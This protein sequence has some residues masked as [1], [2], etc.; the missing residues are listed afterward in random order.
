MW[1]PRLLGGCVEPSRY[2]GSKTHFVVN[3]MNS[4][5]QETIS[6]VLQTDNDACLPTGSDTDTRSS[7][8]STPVDDLERIVQPEVP[9]KAE[10]EQDF[11]DF[12]L[13]RTVKKPSRVVKNARRSKPLK[14]LRA[15]LDKPKLAK[16]CA[17]FLS[18]VPDPLPEF[19][20]SVRSIA[21]DSIVTSNNYQQKLK[22]CP[23]VESTHE[24]VSDINPDL[25][26]PLARYLPYHVSNSEDSYLNLRAFDRNAV[27]TDRKY[28]LRYVKNFSRFR[29][30]DEYYADQIAFHYSKNPHHPEHWHGNHMDFASTVEMMND[31]CASAA[32]LEQ[33]PTSLN[34]VITAVSW[35]FSV[36]DGKTVTNEKFRNMNGLGL[37]AWFAN[38]FRMSVC[39]GAIDRDFKYPTTHRKSI[40]EPFENEMWLLG[41]MAGS[42]ARFLGAVKESKKLKF[43]VRETRYHRWLVDK[44]NAEHRVAGGHDAD[45]ATMVSTLAYA[46][47]WFIKDA[48]LPVH[49]PT[50]DDCDECHTPDPFRH[51][52][53]CSSASRVLN[54]ARNL[55]EG[56]Q[57]SIKN[58]VGD[59]ILS[60]DFA[61][62]TREAIRTIADKLGAASDAFTDVFSQISDMILGLK[63]RILSLM[64]RIPGFSNL[65]DGFS[66][67]N[68][69]KLVICY[70]L[71][72]H[73]DSVVMRGLIAAAA[74]AVLKS[75]V[76][77]PLLRD[78]SLTSL[79]NKISGQSVEEPVIVEPPESDTDEHICT[80]DD[81]IHENLIDRLF[82]YVTDCDVQTGGIVCCFLITLITGR[83]CAT[84][85]RDSI[86]KSFVNTFKNLHFI[87]AGL[88]GM[89]R[90]IRYFSTILKTVINFF[91]LAIGKT[92]A[93]KAEQEKAD[94]L[95]NRAL[96]WVVYVESYR[97]EEGIRL[98]RSSA[99]DHKRAMNLFNES[100]EFVAAAHSGKL[101]RS[102]GIH[103]I[104][105]VSEAQKIF[106]T[107]M[108]MKRHGK[109]R[110]TPFHIQFYGDPGSGKSV[111]LQN[112]IPHLHKHYYPTRPTESLVYNRSTTEHWDGYLGQPI[113]VKDEAYPARIPEKLIEDLAI[114]SC[115]PFLTPQAELHD[116]GAIYLESEFYL[117]S[118]NVPY[119]VC[120]DVYDMRAIHRRRHMLI[121][122]RCD[123]R[124]K[125]PG[126]N[127]F[128]AEL[129]KKHFPGQSSRDFPHLKFDIL[130][131]VTD[132]GQPEVSEECYYGDE[133][134]IPSGLIRPLKDLGYEQLLAL[135]HTRRAA[136]IS[137]EK[138]AFDGGSLQKHLKL[139]HLEIENFKA[140]LL[141]KDPEVEIPKIFDLNSIDEEEIETTE[142]RTSNL[143]E[144]DFRRIYNDFFK[145]K[146]EAVRV[147]DHT[148]TSSD[149]EADLD[150]A[151]ALIKSPDFDLEKLQV[152]YLRVEKVF[153]NS[154]DPTHPS[155]QKRIWLRALTVS[156]LLRQKLDVVENIKT[157]KLFT[158]VPAKIHRLEEVQ[159]T[160]PSC[161]RT[162]PDTKPLSVDEE[163][164]RARNIL[165]NKKRK[166]AENLIETTGPSGKKT[167]RFAPS[168]ETTLDEVEGNRTDRNGVRPCAPYFDM[169]EL[170]QRGHTH[171]HS[172]HRNMSALVLTRLRQNMGHFFP[173]FQFGGNLAP[174]EQCFIEVMPFTVRGG[175]MPLCGRGLV[176][177]T[178]LAG[179]F[180]RI[181]NLYNGRLPLTNYFAALIDK[182]EVDGKTV[183][184]LNTSETRSS[185]NAWL[186][187]VAQ[188]L[189][190]TST[191]D[192]PVPHGF[193]RDKNSVIQCLLLSVP[194][195]FDS[196]NFFMNDITEEERDALY[197]YMRDYTFSMQTIRSF[198]HVVQNT[199]IKKTQSLIDLVGRTCNWVMTSLANWKT[200]LYTLGGA[201]LVISILRGV[202]H[203]IAPHTP[204]S[205]K[206]FRV[207]GRRPVVTRY[208]SGDST[209]LEA[210]SRYKKR[211]IVE[212]RLWNWDSPDVVKMASG[213]R[214]GHYLVTVAHT[215]SAL[216][217]GDDED[218]SHFV[219]EFRPT[220]YSP[221]TWQCTI[222]CGSVYFVP[223]TDIAVTYLRDFAPAPDC[224][225]LFWTEDEA[226]NCDLP[227][228]I[229]LLRLPMGEQLVS[230]YSL[231][232]LAYSHYAFKVSNPCHRFDAPFIKVRWH[233]P[234]G[235][236]GCPAFGHLPGT[237]GRILGLQS[238]TKDGNSY[239]AVLTRE[240]LFDAMS[241]FHPITHEGPI[242]TTYTAIE[243]GG[244]PKSAKYI[245]SHVQL[246]GCVKPEYVLGYT[247]GTALRET[248]L[249]EDFPSV[250]VPALLN[251][252]DPRVPPG[253]H[254]CAHSFNKT[255]RDVMVPLD[256]ELVEMAVDGMS[257]YYIQRL[258]L[259]KLKILDTT[260]TIR[261]YGG[262]EPI[263]TKT[264]PGIPLIWDRKPGFPGKKQF[265]RYTETG[266]I[267]YFSERVK[268]EMEYFESSMEWGVIPEAQMYEFP[269]DELRP[270]LKALGDSTH[271]QKTRTISVFPMVINMLYRKYFL[272]FDAQ[273]HTWADGDFPIS[274][275]MNPEGPAFTNAFYRLR[276]ASPFVMAADISNFDGHW[277]AQLAF[278]YLD[279]IQRC[280]AIA[281]S[282]S[283]GCCKGGLPDC[284]DL[285]WSMRVRQCIFDFNLFGHFQF[286][287]ALCQKQRG[288]SSGFAGTADVNSGSHLL[289]L[290][291][292]YL[293]AMRAY[294]SLC[295]FDEFLAHV[296]SLIY[297]DDIVFS[298]SP[299]VSV[300]FNVNY[301]VNFMTRHGWPITSADKKGKVE[302]ILLDRADFLKRKF[303]LDYHLGVVFAALSLDTISDMLHWI[304][305]SECPRNQLFVNIRL[306]LEY[307]FPH[308]YEVYNEWRD[309]IRE[310]LRN[311]SIRFPLP[312]YMQTRRVMLSRYYGEPQEPPLIGES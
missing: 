80:S 165:R 278:A 191:L 309:R 291:I 73:F 231:P 92:P 41:L 225:R 273:V 184:A 16:T 287:D 265:L 180:S 305:K 190:R 132:T 36:K 268:E 203:F 311:H 107:A 256:P 9:S 50:S 145:D 63:T 144:E 166:L 194:G 254:P 150:Q 205:K 61:D 79:W 75:M 103:V 54:N 146:K 94:D 230:Q 160:E 29:T 142:T 229:D 272:A 284:D 264:S 210:F 62:T 292:C 37:L 245:E 251:P 234:R 31:L 149:D 259:T 242:A 308:G 129:F 280:Y 192:S 138:S 244:F 253:T 275:G 221:E 52:Q 171:C 290:Y 302:P 200:V 238:N 202:A 216:M 258:D 101:P 239:I 48:P 83:F 32:R 266:E 224:H 23:L 270:I 110:A 209:Y 67:L 87:G 279:V 262:T 148:E 97:T 250:S 158:G 297:G 19:L 301:Y 136:M 137:E 106:N 162:V 173:A 186:N 274:V 72:N 227:D 276:H 159:L 219:M 5:N 153:T 89:D 236:S 93:E 170:G 246:V 125:H 51:N 151:E 177:P 117:T 38:V 120:G 220:L 198:Q 100:V 4:Q 185:Y 78:F 282:A 257:D 7:G 147:V 181:L 196:I 174:S 64:E 43:Y 81:E 175:H 164:A 304:R 204:T 11:K 74:L 40:V 223:N 71:W 240:A 217:C 6:S 222:P 140:T 248:P 261:G 188:Q 70:F 99:D 108:R 121:H 207:S 18:K 3:F 135:I 45:K 113:L 10:L 25:V 157:E 255:G 44:L 182:L 49:T 193:S 86:C 235:Y 134:E 161:S 131:S 167:Y 277:T 143:T 293:S 98:L 233:S 42:M 215:F 69:I 33:C 243:D 241:N 237:T 285:E 156:N 27:E 179:T 312:T 213:I 300:C 201:A 56:V 296:P 206:F 263:N 28:H 232:V 39:L 57:T 286:Y 211:C 84:G 128:D 95:A 82:S 20:A 35:C 228:D 119:P 306:A 60:S 298:V 189:L 68:V 247:S 260:E 249:A 187:T 172:I 26:W 55:F 214:C 13:A 85:E 199:V 126:T 127:K 1:D 123:R 183:W 152:M 58:V 66:L 77:I 115:N 295:T 21:C 133:E 76:D 299:I 195:M 14:E 53:G 141:A 118:T 34:A 104:R 114:V 283:C 102:L 17:D 105:L 294:P 154:T 112:L 303:K 122:V 289:L 281:H 24:G 169:L 8:H 47:R 307:L 271:P 109:T 226:K 30:M 22:D 267:E 269:K 197:A 46:W 288:M 90:I 163:I 139:N 218:S 310:S 2:L 212:Y 116:K 12:V 59:T 178:R 155:Y 208:T 124:V 111:L 91:S 96:Q 176:L 130:K 15:A 252:A 168:T 88:F 65:P